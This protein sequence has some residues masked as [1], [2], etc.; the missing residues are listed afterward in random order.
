MNKQTRTIKYKPA[1]PTLT[2]FHASNAFCRYLQGPMGSSKST[3]CVMEIMTRAQEQEPNEQGV[4]R[5]RWAIIRNDFP[6]L[7]QTTVKTW[8]DW[9]PESQFGPVKYGSPFTHYLKYKLGDG[10][11]VDCE[12]LFMSLDQ[13]GDEK[14]LLSLEV[15]G[16]WFNEAS[17]MKQSAF[18]KAQG[19]VGRF[20]PMRE[21]GCTWSGVICDSNPPDVTHWLYKLFT[22]VKPEGFEFFQQPSGRGPNAENLE[23]LPPDYYKKLAAGKKD[24]WIRAYVDGEFAYSLGGMPVHESFNPVIHVRNDNIEWVH[25]NDLIVGM[26]FG[27][28]PACAFISYSKAEHQYTV[29]DEI[30]TTRSNAKEMAGSIQKLLASEYENA[31][32]DYWG[33]PAGEQ[34]SQ[35][36]GGTVFDI[37]HALDIDV[38]AARTN[39]FEIR[40]G[41]L[42]NLLSNIGVNGQ[43]S[44]VINPR[45]TTLVAGL[46]GAYKFKL[47]QTGGA[48]EQFKEL[49]E[50]TIESHVCEA[51]HYGLMGAGEGENLITRGHKQRL[52]NPK[53]IDSRGRTRSVLTRRQ[54]W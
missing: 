44:I 20:P 21:G 6:M 40:Q 30:V 46:S 12:V 19:R 26:D 1:G 39:K 31:H 7:R 10:T 50:K 3:A 4:R 32:P 13:E 5:T 35:T 27:N 51:L 16:I 14:K 25:Y 36:D 37:Y 15:T 47:V 38:R 54:D 17:E 49:P 33:D 53:V 24:S 22:V 28:T 43:P 34:G 9:V 48:N 23:N 11:T 2:R 18:D 52:H 41:A 45:C 8:V 29:H 42:D